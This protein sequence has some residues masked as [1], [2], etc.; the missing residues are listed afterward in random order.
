MIFGIGITCLA[1]VLAVVGYGRR[2]ERSYRAWSAPKVSGKVGPG[3]NVVSLRP[4]A[5]YRR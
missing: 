3:H 1:G 4:V 2:V 5:P